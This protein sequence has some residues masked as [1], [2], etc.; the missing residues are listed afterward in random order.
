MFNIVSTLKG[1]YIDCKEGDIWNV[2][3]GCV[4]L[5]LQCFMLGVILWTANTLYGV[6]Y[7]E[8]VYLE[9][10]LE[11]SWRISSKFGIEY[12]DNYSAK[13]STWGYTTIQY[14]NNVSCLKQWVEYVCIGWGRPGQDG[15]GT[16]R[17]TEVS[18]AEWQNL[19]IGQVT[20][21]KTIVAIKKP[22]SLW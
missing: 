20:E 17:S 4:V 13:K 16:T 3:F 7:Q 9:R 1:I 2:F 6:S 18:Q 10:P 8:E 12:L 15:D 19:S 11:V 14:V 22:K 21:Q 5:A